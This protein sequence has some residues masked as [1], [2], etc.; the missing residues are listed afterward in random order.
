MEI[1]RDDQEMEKDP[2]PPPPLYYSLFPEKRQDNPPINEAGF[3]AKINEVSPINVAVSVARED[4]VSPAAH[5]PY[6]DADGVWRQADGSYMYEEDENI[7]DRRLGEEYER[8]Q[9]DLEREA[10]ILNQRR[11]PLM[12]FVYSLTTKGIIQSIS[13]IVGMSLMI[14]GL[15]MIVTTSFNPIWLIPFAIGLLILII[16]LAVAR[17]KVGYR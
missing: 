8:E 12:R 10:Y 4:E 7:A 17:Y 11:N 15:V 1:N 3:D 13:I 14:L 2:Q 9:R 6:E 5:G 16:T